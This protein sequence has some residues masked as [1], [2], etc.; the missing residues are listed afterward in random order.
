YFLMPLP[1]RGSQPTVFSSAPPETP[2][3]SGRTGDR[4]KPAAAIYLCLRGLMAKIGAMA[5]SFS[6]CRSLILEGILEGL[7]LRANEIAAIEKAP[8]VKYPVNGV[9]LDLVPWHGAIGLSLRLCGE[10]DADIR[11]CNVEWAYFG[12]I[13]GDNCPGLRRAE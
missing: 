2:P 1:G 7:R 11:Y 10:C 5:F 12:L 8:N 13:S 4:H 3:D 6:E 9:S